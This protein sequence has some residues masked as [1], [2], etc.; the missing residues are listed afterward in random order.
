MAIEE[1]AFPDFE[2]WTEHA[3]SDELVRN[4]PDSSVFVVEAEE[5]AG[6]WDDSPFAPPVDAVADGMDA[7]EGAPAVSA[8]SVDAVASFREASTTLDVFRLMTAKGVRRL[9]LATALVQRGIDWGRSRNAERVLLEVRS[10]NK[11]AQALYASVGFV[12]I[13]ERKNYYGTGVDAIIMELPINDL[14]VAEVAGLV[15][16]DPEAVSDDE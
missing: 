6:E 7:M 12:A 15:V 5:R 14:A 8:R 11:A 4:N 13:H 1:I 3:W 2:R 16:P 9:G 10:T